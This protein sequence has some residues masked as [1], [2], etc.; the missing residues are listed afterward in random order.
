MANSLRAADV[1]LN[2]LGNARRFAAPLTFN[3]SA[4]YSERSFF[5]LASVL[6]LALAGLFYSQISRGLFGKISLDD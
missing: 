5:I 1:E 4:W 3:A 6:A 2:F